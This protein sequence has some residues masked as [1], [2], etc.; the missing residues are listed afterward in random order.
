MR[1]ELEDQTAAGISEAGSFN[2]P[3][4]YIINGQLQCQTTN[5]LFRATLIGTDFINSTEAVSLLNF[6]ASREP[7]ITTTEGNFTVGMVRCIEDYRAGANTI[8][9]V[10]TAFEDVVA[11]SSNYRALSIVG[12]VL[13]ILAVI[14]S[15]VVITV[16]CCCLCHRRHGGDSDITMSSF[17][18]KS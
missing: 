18:Y 8:I 15:A 4:E 6:W 2:F 10:N 13:I 1:I 5:A 7:V 12:V 14:I 11:D 3:N 17:K 16:C 9:C